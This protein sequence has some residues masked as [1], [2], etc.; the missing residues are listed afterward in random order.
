MI[1]TKFLTL[2]KV[3]TLEIIN[4]LQKS[5]SETKQASL[6]FSNILSSQSLL[7]LYRLELR[8]E[9]EKIDARRFRAVFLLIISFKY[10]KISI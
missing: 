8:E 3:P 10:T 6:L 1:I 5:P 4:G 2:K 7:P 9:E